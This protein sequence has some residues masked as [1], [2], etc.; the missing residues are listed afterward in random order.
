MFLCFAGECQEIQRGQ[1][2]FPK[3]ISHA[4]CWVFS[5]DQHQARNPHPHLLV[6][7]LIYQYAYERVSPD[8]TTLSHDTTPADSLLDSS[9]TN[10]ISTETNAVPPETNAA[11]SLPKK[12]SVRFHEVLHALPD[13]SDGRW[14]STQSALV[15]TCDHTKGSYRGGVRLKRRNMKSGVDTS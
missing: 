7:I 4:S 8:K 3:L 6:F 11:A 15:C 9:Y 14:N 1:E 2:N 13:R 12:K 5:R 10:T